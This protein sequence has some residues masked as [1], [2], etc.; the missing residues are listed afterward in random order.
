MR[1][2]TSTKPPLAQSSKDD[3]TLNHTTP[4]PPFLQTTARRYTNLVFSNLVTPSWI[5]TSDISASPKIKFLRAW[6]RR[7]TFSRFSKMRLQVPCTSISPSP[8][9]CNTYNRGYTWN[10]AKHLWSVMWPS[11]ISLIHFKFIRQCSLHSEDAPLPSPFCTE[12][13]SY[14]SPWFSQEAN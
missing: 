3:H 13:F 9:I 8:P 1:K 11:F 14:S 7:T 4:S 2:N 10:P 12:E 5:T 6:W